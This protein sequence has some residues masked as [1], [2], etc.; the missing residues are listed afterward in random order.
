MRALTLMKSSDGVH[1]VGLI[2]GAVAYDADGNPLNSTTQDMTVDMK[3]EVFQD[4]VKTG[5]KYTQQMDL[6]MTPVY[7]RLGVYDKVSKR[8]GSM[9]IPLKPKAALPEAPAQPAAVKP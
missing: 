1:H 8:V 5:L 6:P 3:P 7:L 9:E 4:F 2:V